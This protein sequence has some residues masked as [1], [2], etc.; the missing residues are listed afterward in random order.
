MHYTLEQKKELLA[1]LS[2]FLTSA[3]NQRIDEVLAARTRYITVMLE[4]LHQ[5]HNISAVIRSCDCF[6]IQDLHIF[7]QK[8]RYNVNQGIAKGA[9]Q[10]IDVIRHRVPK[11]S[12]EDSLLEL[13]EQGYA[14][15]ATSPHNH[16]YLLQEVPLDSKVALLFGTEDTGLSEEAFQ[17]ADMRVKIPM[18]GFT[19]SFNISVSAA[20]SLQSLV[21]R[22][23][24]GNY[25]WQL[26]DEEK[27]NTKLSWFRRIVRGSV[28][29]E[30]HFFS[31]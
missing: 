4:D 27:L 23:Y 2:Q 28:A 30:K 3:R 26:S 17:L 25:D 19:E 8:N 10:W 11:K 16:D 6:G 31:V 12:V 20:L 13:K 5:S 1:Y 14:I 18:F 7:E 29:L 24:A 9:G 21:T 22:L 15:A